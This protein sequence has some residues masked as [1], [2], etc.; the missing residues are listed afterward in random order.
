MPAGVASLPVETRQGWLLGRMLVD[1]PED[2]DEAMALVEDIWL[3]PL[4]EFT[5]GR[6]PPAPPELKYN[7]DGSLTLLLQHEPPADPAARSVPHPSG[8][9]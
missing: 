7:P 5:P 9:C 1:G 2:F 6:R 3:S 8:L 4:S